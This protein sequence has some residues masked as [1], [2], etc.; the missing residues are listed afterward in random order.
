MLLNRVDLAQLLYI[1]FATGI[2]AKQIYVR[3]LDTI[4]S[5][6]NI[7]CNWIPFADNTVFCSQL[8]KL[9]MKN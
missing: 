2:L 3:Y 4:R 9:F 6:R 7:M 8:F 1:S 5:I